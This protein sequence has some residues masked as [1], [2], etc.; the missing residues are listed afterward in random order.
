MAYLEVVIG[1][2]CPK[3]LNEYKEGT[4]PDEVVALY[5]RIHEEETQMC[6]RCLSLRF[7]DSPLC[8]LHRLMEGIEILTH[9]RLT[10]PYSTPGSVDCALRYRELV[11]MMVDEEKAGV[12][13]VVMWRKRRFDELSREETELDPHKVIDDDNDN[14]DTTDSKGRSV[15]RR[16]IMPS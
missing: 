9:D 13:D 11:T 10:D 5:D 8:P 1:S 7:G 2:V 3:D 16:R 15:K 4:L 12:K 14:D 6:D